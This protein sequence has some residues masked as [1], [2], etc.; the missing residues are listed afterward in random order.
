MTT[1][2]F[3]SHVVDEDY[4]SIFETLIFVDGSTLECS[5]V[6]IIN[7]STVEGTE[8]F[9]IILSTSNPDI[10]ITSPSETNAFILD[11]DGRLHNAVLS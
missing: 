5:S 1:P 8:D 6:T 4:V 11:D 2:F 3:I 10:N 9:S 7:D